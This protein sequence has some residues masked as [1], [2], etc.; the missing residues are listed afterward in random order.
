[1]A[2]LR[3]VCIAYRKI[4]LYGLHTGNETLDIRKIYTQKDKHL[5]TNFFAY[6]NYFS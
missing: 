5:Q 1:M 6:G 3:Q 4:E 2:I